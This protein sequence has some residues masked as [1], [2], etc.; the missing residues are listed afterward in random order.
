MSIELCL[1]KKLNLLITS[2]KSIYF[3]HCGW[4]VTDK[5]TFHSVG[6]GFGVPPAGLHQCPPVCF[7]FIRVDESTDWQSDGTVDES[8]KPWWG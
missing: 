8:T 6:S 2:V 4:I 7:L 1:R 5:S 3:S